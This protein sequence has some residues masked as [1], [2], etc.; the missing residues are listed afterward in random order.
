MKFID[1]FWLVILKDECGPQ[2]AQG[3]MFLNT[4]E[5]MVAGG[6]LVQTTFYFD[7]CEQVVALFGGHEPSCGATFTPFY[8]DPSQRILV[9]YFEDFERLLVIKPETALRLARERNGEDLPW[10]EWNDHVTWVHAELEVEGIWVSGSRLY[11]AYSCDDGYC[12]P[13]MQVYDLSAKAPGRGEEAGKDGSNQY[14]APT[15]TQDLPSELT[16]IRSWY[17]CYDSIVFVL[18]NIPTSQP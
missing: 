8:P 4:K 14:M 9:F 12:V 16:N 10:E 13:S 15:L 2:M 17:G 3:I 11:C 5:T 6:E 18:V 7:P 1:D